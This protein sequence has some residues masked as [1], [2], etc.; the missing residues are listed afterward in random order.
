MGFVVNRKGFVASCCLAILLPL[1][2]L[3]S[4]SV[5]A[6]NVRD[7]I[8]SKRRDAPVVYVG[9]VRD[10][11]LLRRTKYYIQAQANISIS[12]VARGTITTP[13][14]AT[15]RYSTYDDKMPGVAG[16]PSYVL[17]PGLTVLVFADSFEDAELRYLWQGDKAEILRFVEYLQSRLAQ[18]SADQLAFQEVTSEGRETQLALYEKLR[19]YLRGSQ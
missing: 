18:M 2:L 6:A 16:G 1:M 8:E 11:H 14:E 12:T 3:G 5:I 10:V 7:S 19:T 9:V 15:F 4:H 17:R 13:T